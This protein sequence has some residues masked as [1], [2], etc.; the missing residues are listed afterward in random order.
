MTLY[1][2]EIF[3]LVFFVSYLLLA[4][5][6]KIIHTITK[7]HSKDYRIAVIIFS[8]L[9]AGMFTYNQLGRKTNSYPA[10]SPSP[11]SSESSS[12]SPTVSPSISPLTSPEP[13]P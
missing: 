5:I 13:T 4:I 10:I 2:V 11:E 8:L 7:D 6:V 1:D 12:P 3:L 9:A